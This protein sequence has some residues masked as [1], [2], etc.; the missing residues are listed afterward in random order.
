MKRAAEIRGRAAGRTARRCDRGAGDGG[1]ARLRRAGLRHRPRL[2]AQRNLQGAVDAA[3][4]VAGQNLP[5]ATTAYSDAVAYSGATGDKNAVG[6]Y[7][8]TTRLAE[9]DFRVRLA[10]A[11]LHGGNPSDLPGRLE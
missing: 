2:V 9:R 10:R 5:N 7:G 6:G 1:A 11:Q 4:L 3:A 8:V